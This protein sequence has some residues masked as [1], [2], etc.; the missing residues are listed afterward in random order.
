MS[1][2][3]DGAGA[4]SRGPSSYGPVD[5][6]RLADYAAGVLD[7][8]V[9][10]EVE[11]HVRTDDRWARALDALVTADE[12][13]RAE[14]HDLAASDPARMPTDVAGRIEDALRDIVPESS[15]VSLAGARVKRRGGHR[16][17]VTGIAAAAATLV[18]VLCGVTFVRGGLTQN[19]SGTTAGGAPQAENGD[20]GAAPPGAALTTDGGALADASVLVISTG[21]NYT[22]QELRN[23]TA[24]RPTWTPLS[25]Y[26]GGKAG[27]DAAH[28]LSVPDPVAQAAP[29]PLSRLT[30]KTALAACLAAIRDRYPG[31]PALIDY[32]QYE[33][34]PALI[35][36]VVQTGRSATTVVAVGGSC[37]IGGLHEIAVVTGP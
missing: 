36:S 30:G 22:Q 15:V 27:P 35:V 2:A 31:V 26:L 11:R 18:L 12:A 34:R 7:P 3:D 1:R 4:P 24:K 33:G 5:L 16:R 28:E 25:T 20:R 21:I 13:V 6:D 9:A 17:F 8:T 37:G 29:R 32:A 10:A 23:L 19:D 14:L